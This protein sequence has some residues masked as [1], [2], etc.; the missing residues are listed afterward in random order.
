VEIRER[1]ERGKDARRRQPSK[2][3][4]EQDERRVVQ[5]RIQVKSRIKLARRRL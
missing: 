5:D 3:S 1:K 2:K 4:R